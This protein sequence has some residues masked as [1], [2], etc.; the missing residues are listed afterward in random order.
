MALGKLGS[1]M[2]MVSPIV[3]SGVGGG[4][5]GSF[6]SANS[7]GTFLFGVSPAGI[8]AIIS[9]LC[10]FTIFSR[11]SIVLALAGFDEGKEGVR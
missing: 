7:P 3:A 4:I 9:S 8:L 10:I 11:A 2:D 5:I 6:V 1:F